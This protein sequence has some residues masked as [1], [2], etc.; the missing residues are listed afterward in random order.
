VP[1]MTRAFSLGHVS[2][3][4]YLQR[5]PRK[6]RFVDSL[7]IPC[8]AWKN[9]GR[10]E[11]QRG[12]LNRYALQHISVP[13]FSKTRLPACTHGS[14][15]PESRPRADA[16]CGA[17]STRRGTPR[18]RGGGH[19]HGPRLWCAGTGFLAC[20]T[21]VLPQARR[22][23]ASPTPSEPLWLAPSVAAERSASRGCVCVFDADAA[24]TYTA[25]RFTDAWQTAPHSRDRMQPLAWL[26]DVLV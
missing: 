3:K 6:S 8:S 22:A 13:L 18:Q 12:H 10:S 5:C 1:L 24:V 14:P 16:A 15:W 9:N 21:G 17:A 7:F 23:L 4:L 20:V 2:G 19:A 26:L 11:D 25:A